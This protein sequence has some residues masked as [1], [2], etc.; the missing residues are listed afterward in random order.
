M[1]KGMTRLPG[2]Q[3]KVGRDPTQRFTEELSHLNEFTTIQRWGCQAQNWM[4][5]GKMIHAIQVQST[6]NWLKLEHILFWCLKWSYLSVR[7]HQNNSVI[8]G[9]MDSEQREVESREKLHLNQGE[10]WW[11]SLPTSDPTPHQSTEIWYLQSWSFSTEVQINHLCD[12]WGCLCFC[13]HCS[14]LMIHPHSVYM[15]FPQREK[16]TTSWSPLTKLPSLPVLSL[17]VTGRWPKWKCW[18]FP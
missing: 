9:M 13:F 15:G 5:T 10:A 3:D 17:W 18:V 8:L 14:R 4:I 6:A 2:S 7:H 12:L 1:D 11:H 16:I